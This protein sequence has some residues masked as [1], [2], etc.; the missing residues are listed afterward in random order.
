[1]RVRKSPKIELVSCW[2][3]GVVFFLTEPVT[4]GWCGARVRG[5]KTLITLLFKSFLVDQLRVY[6]S[7]LLLKRCSYEIEWLKVILSVKSY[8]SS[9]VMH[10]SDPS[11]F[12]NMSHPYVIFRGSLCRHAIPVNIHLKNKAKL[13]HWLDR[14]HISSPYHTAYT[15]Q[16]HHLTTNM[17]NGNCHK[18]P[19]SSYEPV[20]LEK[21]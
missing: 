13:Q 15:F 18:L 2:I 21:D 7:S 5:T 11:S 8:H 20:I 3:W 4:C 19:Y 6:F 12:I 14:S 1:M 17:N 16:A 9:V 10:A